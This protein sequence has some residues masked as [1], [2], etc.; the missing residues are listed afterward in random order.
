[1]NLFCVIPHDHD[2]TSFYRALQPVSQLRK[3]M[4][5]LQL[6]FSG[7]EISMSHMSPMD[8]VFLQRPAGIEHLQI[9][10]MAKLLKIPV[11]IDYDDNLFCLSPSN[12]QYHIYNNDQTKRVIMELLKHADAISVSTLQ[13]AKD[14]IAYVPEHGKIHIIPNA[15]NDYVLTD[16]PKF[17]P[18]KK[19]VLWRGSSSHQGCLH[20]HSEAIVD[21]AL[22]H[23]DW[24]FQFMGYN[25]WFILNKIGE[26]G[27]FVDPVEIL[28]YHRVI[29]NENPNISIVA[30]N[31]NPFNRCKSNIAWLEGMYSGAI[32]LGPNWEEW[33]KPGIINYSNKKEFQSHLDDMLSGDS[34]DMEKIHALGWEY[35]MEFLTLSKTNQS[36]KAMLEGLL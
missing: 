27:R 2:A 3:I 14:L 6:Y 11:W 7:K 10:D 36:R 35:I 4:P 1:M 22:K 25:P 20:E 21:V 26:Q 24:K 5:N 17:N 19:L 29:R 9:M 13:L 8:V 18:D 16:Q 15:L 23:K 28:A 31:D 34:G 30:L 32:C 12:P 33:D